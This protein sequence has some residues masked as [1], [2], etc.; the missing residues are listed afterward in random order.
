MDAQQTLFT[1]AFSTELAECGLVT[2]QKEAT[3]AFSSLSHNF[4]QGIFHPVYRIKISVQL[5]V[6]AVTERH[7]ALRAAQKF[8]FLVETKP[9][10]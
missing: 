8:S 9:H 2:C 3:C 6:W 10:R 1:L 7:T 5:E 4:L